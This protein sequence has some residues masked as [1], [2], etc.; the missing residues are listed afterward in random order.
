MNSC[1]SSPW[2]TGPKVGSIVCAWCM[3]YTLWLLVF[4]SLRNTFS[5][6]RLWACPR[7]I[8]NHTITWEDHLYWDRGSVLCD[9]EYPRTTGVSHFEVIVFHRKRLLENKMVVLLFIVMQLVTFLFLYAHYFNVTWAS[10]CSK[11]DNSIVCSTARLAHNKENIEV[12]C[13]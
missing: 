5:W 9:Q 2:D 13:Y 4:S 10:L 6:G 3:R 12:P 11:Y 8:D 7:I 1:N